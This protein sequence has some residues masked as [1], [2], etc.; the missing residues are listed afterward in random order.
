[1]RDSPNPNSARTVTVIVSPS[2]RPVGAV[3][4]T[5]SQ[6]RCLPE[7]AQMRLRVSS[8][9]LTD[10]RRLARLSLVMTV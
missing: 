8:S 6:V 9:V 10:A 7:P 5:V 1:M 4:L 2:V 3:R